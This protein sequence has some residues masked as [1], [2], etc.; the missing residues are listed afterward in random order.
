MAIN[1]ALYFGDDHPW[2]TVAVTVVAAAA[3]A[4]AATSTGSLSKHKQDD[5]EVVA[6]RSSENFGG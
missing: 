2:V 5:S 6:A 4:A 3:A 1:C